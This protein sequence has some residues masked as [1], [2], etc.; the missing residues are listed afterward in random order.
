LV[1]IWHTAKLG[2]IAGTHVH[3]FTMKIS[4]IWI[5]LPIL[6]DGIQEAQDSQITELNSPWSA[7]QV[8]LE[9]VSE[10]VPVTCK[11]RLSKLPA[12]STVF[13][14]K[15]HINESVAVIAH[16]MESQMR[17][18]PCFCVCRLASWIAIMLTE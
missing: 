8:R 3:D 14:V 1:L 10:I 9:L 18:A 12:V 4:V 17:D 13:K 2:P 6:A 11:L 5:N 15:R 7:L 16:R